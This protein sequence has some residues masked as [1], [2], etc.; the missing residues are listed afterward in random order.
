MLLQIFGIVTIF[1]VTYFVVKTAREY[2]RSPFLWGLLALGVGFGCQW[3][4]P[5][6]LGIAL[7]IV[8]VLTGTK[9]TELEAAIDGPA[10]ILYFAAFGLSF[11]G[12]FMVLK[13]VSRIP[14]DP[15]PASV[16]V[17]PPPSFD[18]Q[19]AQPA[20]IDGSLRDE[21]E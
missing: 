10:T 13:Y 19:T 14:D 18:D 11:V 7:A 16:S 17:P 21:K 2:N 15:E 1:V 8:Y 12:L 5:I 3:V 4:L 9:Q 20:Q 6:V